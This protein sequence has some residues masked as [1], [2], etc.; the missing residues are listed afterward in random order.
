MQ[1]LRIPQSSEGCCVLGHAS[2][3]VIT[4]FF[5]SINIYLAINNGFIVMASNAKQNK[6]WNWNIKFVW[7]WS[8]ICILWK[9]E[10]QLACDLKKKNNKFTTW[11]ILGTE[12]FLVPGLKCLQ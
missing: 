10:S 9:V 2:R 3:E 1:H 12:K 5:S 4:F 7:L 11:K 6:I 8:G